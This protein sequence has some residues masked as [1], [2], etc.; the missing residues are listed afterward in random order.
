MIIRSTNVW[1]N[2]P[3]S[4]LQDEE[5]IVEMDLIPM[6]LFHDTDTPQQITCE[7]NLRRKHDGEMDDDP[8]CVLSI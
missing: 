2:D 8:V 1:A 6:A 3:D 4:S 7:V 5:A